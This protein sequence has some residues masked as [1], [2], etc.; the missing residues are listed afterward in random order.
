MPMTHVNQI[1]EKYL[2]NE[3]MIFNPEFRTLYNSSRFELS[4]ITHPRV[5]IVS[6]KASSLSTVKEQF[7]SSQQNKKKK[8][9]LSDWIYLRMIK[10]QRA[11]ALDSHSKT[12]DVYFLVNMLAAASSTNQC[13]SPQ[14]G[15]TLA[16]GSSSVPSSSNTCLRTLALLAPVLT[17]TEHLAALMIG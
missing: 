3:E 10:L 12:T 1:I 8:Q 4:P 11:F 2:L 9:N 14:T 7:I 13:R 17:N 16:A 15:F 6:C 5:D